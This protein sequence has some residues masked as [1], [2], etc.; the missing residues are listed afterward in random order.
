MYI[1]I[2]IYI[3]IYIY[4]CIY[5]HINIYINIYIYVYTF[6]YIYIYLS[7]SC[8][9]HTMPWPHQHTLRGAGLERKRTRKAKRNT[10]IRVMTSAA[11]SPELMGMGPN[12][13]LDVYICIYIYIYVY[14][15]I[16]I[17]YVCIYIY[18]YTIGSTWAML[19]SFRSPKK[20][21]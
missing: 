1:Y 11:R 10:P 14:I 5:I 2:H 9:Q 21:V 4:I 17:L 19:R 16:Y 3:Y 18:I 6:I 8:I 12:G 7:S 15:Y 20:N 13:F